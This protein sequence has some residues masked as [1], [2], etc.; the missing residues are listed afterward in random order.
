PT[1]QNPPSHFNNFHIYPTSLFRFITPRSIS[2]R[3]LG[4]QIPNK[5]RNICSTAKNGIGKPKASRSKSVSR[6]K[7]AGLEFPVGRVAQNFKAGKYSDR[8]SAEASVYLMAV[9]EYLLAEVIIFCTI[10]VFR[11]ST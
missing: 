5:Y 8:V 11:F 10:N 3:V 1:N 2:S 9:L 6:S 7:R 4:Y